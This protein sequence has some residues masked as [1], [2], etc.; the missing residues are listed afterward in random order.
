MEFRQLAAWCSGVWLAVVENA[1][2]ES[3]VWYVGT[4]TAT[5]HERS[6]GMNTSFLLITL[7]AVST[8]PADQLARSIVENGHKRVGVVPL[9]I[10]RNPD[11]ETT[12]SSTLGP[13]AATKARD[14][15]E[16]LI[17]ASKKG[18]YS[19]KFA[20]IPERTMYNA[21]R[22]VTVEQL[23]DPNVMQAVHE[24]TGA[25]AV[26]TSTYEGPDVRKVDFVDEP[27]PTPGNGGTG[28]EGNTEGEAL[29][30][31][32][33]HD[34]TD[35][36]GNATAHEEELDKWNLFTAAYGNGESWELLRWEGDTLTSRIGMEPLD[37]RDGWEQRFYQRTR[38]LR[39]TEEG[40]GLPHPYRIDDFPYA[41]KMEVGGEVRTPRQI[42]ENYVVA[43]NPGEEYKILLANRTDKNVYVALFVDGVCTIDKQ[44]EEPQNLPVRRHW[45]LPKNSGERRI[46]GWQ[47]I[48]RDARNRPIGTPSFTTFRIVDAGN[49][50][51]RGAGFDQK[52]GMITAIFY[53]VGMPTVGSSARSL[54][55]SKVGTGEGQRV[56]K[57]LKWGDSEKRGV[58]LAAVTCY[59]RS[60][61]ELQELESGKGDDPV[62]DPGKGQ[63]GSEGDQEIEFPK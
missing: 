23:A 13:R 33:S 53:T 63:Q 20:V 17:V 5:K 2:R 27:D 26:V 9:V 55:P 30:G 60:D 21:L 44:I 19:G 48:P 62:L 35:K 54:N 57:E 25:D 42:G 15:Y 49:S 56:E 29:T 37:L 16:G 18:P 51:A 24:Q 10:T 41:L 39:E 31:T 14:L 52:I 38:E 45:S 7:L 22:N 3:Q 28:T 58:M 47:T 36:H 43:L 50:V 32:L 11:G 61:A 59:Y 4:A 34:L 12:A 6:H 46:Q 40:K 8:N 1:Q